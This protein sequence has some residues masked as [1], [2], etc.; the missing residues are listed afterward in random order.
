[1]SNLNVQSLDVVAQQIGAL[2]S[3]VAEPALLNAQP[4]ELKETF[5]VWTLGLDA[6][7]HGVA[8]GKSLSQ[9]ARPTGRWHHQI[10]FAGNASAFARS[11]MSPEDG[12]QH[13]E[14]LFISPLAAKTDQAIDWID[15]NTSG[16]PFVTLLVVPAYYLHALW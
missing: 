10:A 9:I 6:L 14:E 2:L 4:I 11:S 12:H 1:T 7:A 15:Q 3:D 13:V 16:D 8:T 5:E